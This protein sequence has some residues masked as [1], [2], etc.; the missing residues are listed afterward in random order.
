[1]AFL[2]K[3]SDR[4]LKGCIQ[5]PPSK[6]ESARLLFIDAILG[7]EELSIENLSESTDT[8]ILQ[9]SLES[10][11][12]LKGTNISL[13]LDVHDSGTAMRFV[14][15][16]AANINVKSYITGSER[17][18]HRPLGILVEKLRELGSSISYAEKEGFPPIRI[19]GKR[20]KGGE[21]E[22]DATVSSQFVSAL[23][24]LA[25]K[26]TN[27]LKMKMTGKVISEPYIDMTIKIMQDLGIV[28]EREGNTI[29]IKKQ[30]YQNKN[31]YRV[32]SD[33]SA[34]SYW[35]QLAAFA[36][37]VDL[38]LLGLKKSSTQGDHIIAEWATK[39]GVQTEFIENGVRLSKTKVKASNLDM[40]FYLNPDL[41][42]T[43]IVTAAGLQ[44]AGRFSGLSNLRMKETD[45]IKALV[46]ELGKLGA[47][48][49]ADDDRILLLP[50]KLESKQTV[51]V[52]AD[53]RMAMSFAPLSMLLGDI[54]ID[55]PSVVSKSYPGFWNDMKSAGFQISKI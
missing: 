55:N 17:M 25:P 38:T 5:L 42:Q 23:L 12:R 29:D 35:Y 45:R 8:K 36:D 10:L 20:L 30:R 27:G 54:K 39:F 52:Y 1:M 37:E 32:E 13:N 34:A 4:I 9:S 51:R 6:S 26:M 33:W 41:A 47:E 43:M 19:E 40:D 11:L 50:S 18:K 24:L 22:I 46:T 7:A 15:A 21:I 14:T 28:V 16:Y 2:I 49:S 31:T 53:H 44:I 3:K 48:I